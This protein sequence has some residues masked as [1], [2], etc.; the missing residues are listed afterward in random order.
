MIVVDTGP[1]V[2]VADADDA[3][4]TECVDLVRTHHRELVVPSTVVVE[5]CWLLE[6]YLGS[7]AE[8]AFLGSLARGELRVEEVG[9]SDYQRMAELVEEYADLR[10]GTVDAS[11][12][13]LAERLRVTS[14]LTTN[15]RDFSV[16]R[17]RHAAAFALIP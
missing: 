2:A 16:V 17:P 5:V 7:A 10:L 8:A 13:A 9:R 11:V 3:H 1:L 12:V 15:R 6:K 4:H 14:L